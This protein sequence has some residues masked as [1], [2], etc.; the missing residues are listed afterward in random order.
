KATA[1][2]AAGITPRLAQC[3]TVVEHLAH[4]YSS[5]K[6]SASMRCTL[7]TPVGVSKPER[8][9][10]TFH[11]PNMKPPS[12]APSIPRASR[13]QGLSRPSSK[14]LLD[15]AA[16]TLCEWGVGNYL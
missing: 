16:N 4:S 3:A 14:P 13:A 2:M 11:T 10:D 12:E 8:P 6:C 5:E 15:C 1:R 9:L 7:K